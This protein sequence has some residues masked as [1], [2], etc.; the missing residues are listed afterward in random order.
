M[1]FP[2]VS[3]QGA[4]PHEH[5]PPPM[6]VSPEPGI[7]EHGTLAAARP[8]NIDL[9]AAFPPFEELTQERSA[10]G[11]DHASEA[12]VTDSFKS[13]DTGFEGIGGHHSGHG[14]RR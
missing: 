4:S 2:T 6:D 12:A 10:S 1:P 7:A 3:L 9:K 11:R 13:Y 5:H 14:H 8:G